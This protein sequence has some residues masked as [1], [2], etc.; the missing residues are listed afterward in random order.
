MICGGIAY[1]TVS[2]Y[3]ENIDNQHR[4]VTGVPAYEC[5]QCGDILYD[6]VVVEELESILDSGQPV[7]TQTIQAP[8][9]EFAALS[10]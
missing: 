6:D 9:Y 2:T 1:P 5:N 10:A 3:E 7:R 8:V 4:I